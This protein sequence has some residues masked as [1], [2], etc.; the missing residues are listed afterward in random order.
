MR[1]IAGNSGSSSGVQGA[2]RS[3][4]HAIPVAR[5][6][7]GGEIVLKIKIGER[8]CSSVLEE[9]NGELITHSV[10]IIHQVMSL[11]RSL[12]PPAYFITTQVKT[13][14]LTEISAD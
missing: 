6:L 13:S 5:Q 12:S 10:I 9:E 8:K 3:I 14:T 11:T 4:R 1:I 2:S 7:N